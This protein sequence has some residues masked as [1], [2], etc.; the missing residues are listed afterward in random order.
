MEPYRKLTFSYILCKCND[1]EPGPIDRKKCL[2]HVLVTCI[3]R[4]VT[5]V[6]QATNANASTFIYPTSHGNLTY[7]LKAATTGDVYMHLQAPATYQWIGVGTGSE[8][9]GSVMFIVYEGAD[10]DSK[11][12]QYLQDP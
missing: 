2:T 9:D 8:M 11:C 6:S 12:T 10:K 1:L 4:A 3:V 7:A 5:A